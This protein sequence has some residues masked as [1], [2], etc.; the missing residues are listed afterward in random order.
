LT[1]SLIVTEIYLF[2]KLN[3]LTDIVFFSFFASTTCL[4]TNFTVHN[5]MR[6][7]NQYFTRRSFYKRKAMPRSTNRGIM[8]HHTDKIFPGTNHQPSSA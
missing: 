6:M 2:E 7:Q 8:N 1:F 4:D 5:L 3:I